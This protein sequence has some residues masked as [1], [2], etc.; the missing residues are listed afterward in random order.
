LIQ[1]ANKADDK[2]RVMFSEP[3][4]REISKR[5]VKLLDKIS[6][7]AWDAINVD[8]FKYIDDYVSGVN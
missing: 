1:K 4:A 7:E 2:K 8:L 3:A 5:Y 6:D